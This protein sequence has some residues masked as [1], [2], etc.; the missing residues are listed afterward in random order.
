MIDKNDIYIHT[1]IHTGMPTTK[2]YLV[3]EF[4]KM[5]IEPGV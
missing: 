5:I 2:M 1:Y 4:T 3:S